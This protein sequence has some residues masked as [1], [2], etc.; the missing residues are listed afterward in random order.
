MSDNI[1]ALNAN[2][3]AATSGSAGGALAGTYPNPTL[4]TIASLVV[5]TGAAGI[6]GTTTLA[7]GTK[8]VNTTAVTASSIV[9]VSYNTPKSS[10]SGILSAPSA[11]ISAGAHFVIN[12][13]DATDSTS[14]VN[15]LIIN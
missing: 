11:S 9:L 15:W 14:T 5:A 10:P 7:S 8:T 6:V 3:F 4:A 13:S 12:S 1:S 2:V